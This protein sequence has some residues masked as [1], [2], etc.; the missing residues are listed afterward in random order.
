[1]DELQRLREEIERSQ[2]LAANITDAKTLAR[3][4]EYIE[5]LEEREQQLKAEIASRD[6]PPGSG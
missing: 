1:L 3:L 2:R 6:Q 4:R 5:D